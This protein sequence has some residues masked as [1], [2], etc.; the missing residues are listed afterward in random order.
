[1]A[2]I[3]ILTFGGLNSIPN[4]FACSHKILQNF[5]TVSLWFW[6]NIT[7]QFCNGTATKGLLDVAARPQSPFSFTRSLKPLPKTTVS[8]GRTLPGREMGSAVRVTP[9]SERSSLHLEWFW[10]RV[11]KFFMAV[12]RCSGVTRVNSETDFM[13]LYIKYTEKLWAHKANTNCFCT[14]LKSALCW[15][16][17]PVIMHNSGTK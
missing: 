16:V 3:L 9:H 17:I 6:V 7:A 5:L 15:S 14:Y 13:T 12:T 1:M 8:E 4:L 11:M 10:I 2:W